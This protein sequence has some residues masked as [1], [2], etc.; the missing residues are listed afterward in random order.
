MSEK[1][2]VVHNP[3]PRTVAGWVRKTELNRTLNDQVEEIHLVLV[4]NPEYLRWLDAVYDEQTIEGSLAADNLEAA[5]MIREEAKRRKI[6]R[7]AEAKKATIVKAMNIVLRR[8]GMARTDRR[9]MVG[10]EIV[11]TGVG[12]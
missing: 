3:V 9:N 7:V 5:Q 1:S 8:Y 6:T 4:E 2:L 10:G 11:P 12:E